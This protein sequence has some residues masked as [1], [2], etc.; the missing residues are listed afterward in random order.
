MM[1]NI[2]RLMYETMLCPV[3]LY[4]NNNMGNSF[5]FS[6]LNSTNVS[7]YQVDWGFPEA[8]NIPLLWW[9]LYTDYY[10]GR[11]P[12]A[13]VVG[14]VPHNALYLTSPLSFRCYQMEWESLVIVTF[15]ILKSS[16]CKICEWIHHCIRKWK[17][18]R[19]CH[20]TLNLLSA[21]DPTR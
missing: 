17:K 3:R 15:Y 14:L 16:F 4:S 1:R 8:K 9:A 10:T 6:F 20:Q 21:H 19:I 7:S 18:W 12:R 11:I 13:D 2:P 5:F